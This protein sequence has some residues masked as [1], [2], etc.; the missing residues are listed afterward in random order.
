MTKPDLDAITLAGGK[1]TADIVDAVTEVKIDYSTDTVAQLTL[2]V[3]DAK[4]VLP[5]VL[6]TAGTALTWLGEPWQVAA[7][8]SVYGSDA[9]LLRTFTARSALARALR[10]RYKATVEKKVSPSQWVT[11]RATTAGGRVTCQASAKQST[12]AQPSGRDRQ[13]DLDV[14]ANLASDLQW[15]WV[16]WDGR[17]FFGSR[18]WAWQTGPTGRSWPVTWI[19][20]E[21][22]DVLSADL[23]VDDD[24][25]DNAVTGTLELPYRFGRKVRPWDRLQPTG[26]G[27]SGLL[28][29]EQV[30]ITADGASPVQVQVSQ[31]RPPAKKAGSSS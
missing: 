10:R 21:T 8:S 5:A 15:S 22:T 2:T 19:R 18:H 30:S 27:V 23:A 24:D 16:E 12:I 20:D 6:L 14:I 25:T 28:L 3:S 1:L 17:L 11:G 29:V 9:T 4:A 26:L 31:P 13:S 7:R